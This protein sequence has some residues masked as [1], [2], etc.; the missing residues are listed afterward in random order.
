[1]KYLQ[2]NCLVILVEQ[3]KSY[4]YSDQVMTRHREMRFLGLQNVIGAG[5]NW[6]WN[7]SS[8]LNDKTSET[9]GE[10]NKNEASSKLKEVVL[11]R[12]LPC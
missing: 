10:R 8:G 2:G 5:S 4:N 12:M 11:D 9:C 3:V 6:G 1:M 7:F